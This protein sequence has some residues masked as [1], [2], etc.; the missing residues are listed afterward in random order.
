MRQNKEF[1]E[2]YMQLLL[3]HRN[4]IAENKHI[5]FTDLNLNLYKEI[6]QQPNLKHVPDWITMP[7]NNKENLSKNTI[8][9]QII[10]L[11][12]NMHKDGLNIDNDK[13]Q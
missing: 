6:L 5:A 8:K 1:A 12:Q 4:L 10:A 13:I 2:R 9:S 3:K 11:Y 7:K